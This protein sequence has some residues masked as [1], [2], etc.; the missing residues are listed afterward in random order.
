MLSL[1]LALAAIPMSCANRIKFVPGVG[2][3]P[4]TMSGAAIHRGPM[5]H[6]AGNRPH[7]RMGLAVFPDDSPDD[8]NPE[9]LLDASRL[10]ALFNQPSAPIES[11]AKLPDLGELDS[12]DDGPGMWTDKDDDGEVVPNNTSDGGITPTIGRSNA[13]P[14]TQVYAMD[15]TSLLYKWYDYKAKAARDKVLT[16]MRQSVNFMDSEKTLE[17]VASVPEDM[18]ISVLQSGSDKASESVLALGVFSREQLKDD[19]SLRN[20]IVERHGKQET[21]QRLGRA[22]NLAGMRKQVNVFSIEGLADAPGVN[23]RSSKLL[24]SK[25]EKYA[26]SE[27]RLVVVPERAYIIDGETDLTPYYVRLG[28]EKVEMNDGLSYLLYMGADLSSPTD[29]FV[30]QREVLIGI[31]L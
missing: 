4:R 2:V 20:K 12:S 5:L 16:I 11:A 22:R 23:E 14:P 6:T 28:F 24:M 18:K 9:M 27:K 30:A 3:G 29:A 26:L 19:G 25:I 8:D 1:F 15:A 7:P 17:A 10:N 21:R 31:D 13:F